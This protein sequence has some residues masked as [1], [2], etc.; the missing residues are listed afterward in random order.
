MLRGASRPDRA[1][2]RLKIVLKQAIEGTAIQTTGYIT[3]YSFTMVVDYHLSDVRTGVEL[4]KGTETAVSGYDVVASPYA[5][6]VAQQDA[7]KF[8]ARDIADRVRIDLGVYFTKRT[9]R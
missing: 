5:T 2:Y 9:G 8:G 6:L 4:T 7:Q 3:R 1:R